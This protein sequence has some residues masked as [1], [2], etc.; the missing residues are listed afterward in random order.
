[1]KFLALALLLVSCA[2][3]N[4]AD[5]SARAG[6]NGSAQENDQAPR[7]FAN[8]G[9]CVTVDW[10]QL[11]T[12]SDFGSFFFHTS[13]GDPPLP[14]SVLLWM[15]SMGH[16]SSPVTVEKTGV[17]EYHA[18]KVFFAMKGVWQLRFQLKSGRE[19]KDEVILPF[20]F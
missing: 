1:M 13:P 15:P 17:G 7:C 6:A 19:V 2:Q 10:E 11:P 4:Y 9:P 8:K 18:T 20:T 14:P 12:E 5:D 3:P 16:G